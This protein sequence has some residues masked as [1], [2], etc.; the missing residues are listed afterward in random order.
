MWVIIITIIIIIIIII[1]IAIYCILLCSKNYFIPNTYWH[2]E[3]VLWME[4][5]IKFD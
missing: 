1:T 3:L 4:N 2:A 5:L